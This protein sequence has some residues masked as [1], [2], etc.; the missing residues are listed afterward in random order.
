MAGQTDQNSNK[1]TVYDTTLRDGAQ[2]EGVYFSLKDKI[3]YLN[4]L[5]AMGVPYIEGGWPG[6][7]PRDAALFNQVSQLRLTQTKVVAFGST[8]KVGEKAE[9]SEILRQLLSSGAQV[10]TIF[11]KAWDLHVAEVLKTTLKENLRIIRDSIRF[12]TRQGRRVFFDAEHFFD[13]WKDHPGYALSCVQTAVEAGADALV[14]C[15]TNG[16]ALPEEI[17]A[18][19][20]AVKARWGDI[21]IGIHAHNDGGLAVANT[22]AAVEAGA[23][24]IQGT[25]NGFGERCG[26]ANLST[27][28]PW[29]QLKMHWDVFPDPFLSQITHLARFVAEL[30]NTTFD[31]RQPYVGRSAFAHKAGMHVDAVIKNHRTFEHIDPARVGNERRLLIS[32]QSGKSN[33]WQR[34]QRFAPDIAKD[35]KRVKKVIAQIKE[36]ENR[37]FQFEIAEGSL[38]LLILRSLAAFKE[39]F[40]LLDYHVLIDPIRGEADSV[41]VVKIQVEEDVVH[42]A[43]NGIGPVNALDMALRQALT[44]FFPQLEECQLVDYKVRVLDGSSGTEAVVRVVVETA[45]P[46]ETWGTIGVSANILKAS[47]QAL[48]DGLYTA[49]IKTQ[50]SR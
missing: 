41:A 30:V 21:E 45:L 1:I 6:A 31:D 3:L 7:N 16:G 24:Q 38:D 12:L 11:G 29:L 17:K 20:A 25:W 10:I 39:P 37:G 5:D 4:K 26:N 36:M 47:S 32:D 9:E 33:V 19:V 49:I 50:K 44:P 43:S 18:G 22:L 48:I 28:V 13:A 46:N 34:M 35:D 14:L 42:V 8:C 15:D 2:A 40:K 23:R 27:I